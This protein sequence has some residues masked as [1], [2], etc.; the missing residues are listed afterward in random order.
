MNKLGVINRSFRGGKR[1]WVYL[2]LK[3]IDV[4]SDS[5]EGKQMQMLTMRRT[6][7]STKFD[8]TPE[9]SDVSESREESNW[10]LQRVNISHM[11]LSLVH[12]R[13]SIF[14]QPSSE[15]CS[16][17]RVDGTKLII[18]RNSLKVASN[19]AADLFRDGLSQDTHSKKF[20]ASQTD[21]KESSE[22]GADSTVDD[23]NVSSTQITCY[24]KGSGLDK[25]ENTYQISCDLE[26]DIFT[27]FIKKSCHQN[28]E[29]SPFVLVKSEPTEIT[30]SQ[31]ASKKLRLCATETGKIK[32]DDDD[33]ASGGS[34]PVGLDLCIKQEELSNKQDRGSDSDNGTV[35]QS[36]GSGEKESGQDTDLN[37]K[38]EKTDEALNLS[39]KSQTDETC[40]KITTSFTPLSHRS[41][42]VKMQT[43]HYK[44]LNAQMSMKQTP[45]NSAASSPLLT[46]MS[47]RSHSEHD[48]ESEGKE[49]ISR[50]S[51][52]SIPRL[53]QKRSFS[54]M[55]GREAEPICWNS[56][57][58]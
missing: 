44:P 23:R 54:V 56:L 29:N 43:I 38:L 55:N 41:S 10:K 17:S 34:S 5:E 58:V 51:D 30:D 21:H 32:D 48:W 22:I 35:V 13:N 52:P 28:A 57:E 50:S 20:F 18:N 11:P 26:R 47:A 27:K 4:D 2:N 8:V 37:I 14:K 12:N 42:Q 25:S 19:N 45:L 6:A 3:P 24:S 15:Y 49:N 16:V 7:R 39:K 40:S 31:W 36:S 46:L 9:G 33:D 53:A 1:E